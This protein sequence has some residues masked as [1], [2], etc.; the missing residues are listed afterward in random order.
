VQE[1]N[2]HQFDRIGPC[3]GLLIRK[4]YGGFFCRGRRIFWFGGREE[5]QLQ[6]FFTRQSHAKNED[7]SKRGVDVA[8]ERDSGLSNATSIFD[9]R[10]RGLS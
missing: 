2:D 8:F 7:Q 6:G 1:R 5:H 4:L 9:P 3:G 10:R